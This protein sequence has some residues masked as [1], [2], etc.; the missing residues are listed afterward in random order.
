MV[1]KLP[2][3]SMHQ[4]VQIIRD[5]LPDDKKNDEINEVPLD[6]LDTLT[7]RKLQRFVQVSA[8]FD[9]TA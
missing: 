7:L 8:Y 1:A 5:G 2:H 3:D 9:V 4:L 6:I